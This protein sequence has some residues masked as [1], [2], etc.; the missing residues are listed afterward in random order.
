MITTFRGRFYSTLNQRSSKRF[1]N[2]NI[3]ISSILNIC[4]YLYFASFEDMFQKKAP[5]L[6]TTGESA[7]PSQTSI[8]TSF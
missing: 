3:V 4:F 6:E 8:A 7:I 2:L 5:G 1:K